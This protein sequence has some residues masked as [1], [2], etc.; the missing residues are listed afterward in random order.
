MEG[1]VTVR[2][3]L[4]TTSTEDPEYVVRWTGERAMPQLIDT[5]S[6]AGTLAAAVN[7]LLVTEGIP[8]LTLRKIAWVSRVSAG[9]I[10]HHLGDKNRLLSL[11]AALTVRAHHDDI[12]RRS[13]VQG[14]LA[15]LPDDDDAVLHTRAWLGW[16][17]LGRSD[18]VVEIPIHR[19]RRE[20]RGLLAEALDYRLSRDDLDLTYAM[21]EG[22]RTAICE[23]ARPMPPARA[24]ALLAG[25]L[26]R[27]GVSVTPDEEVP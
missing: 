11:C 8:G 13:W 4:W 19:A 12:Q 6:R 17:E 9:S 21:I 3:S 23:P 10:I 20:E 5:D 15:F 27:L 25:H 14:V 24:H 2:P 16:V 22:L 18:P 7:E 26:R 1:V